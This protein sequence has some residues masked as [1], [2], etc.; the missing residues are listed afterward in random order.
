MLTIKNDAWKE[1]KGL[2]KPVSQLNILKRHW[3]G[4]QQIYIT[5]LASSERRDKECGVPS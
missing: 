4:Q 3:H 1:G 2:S 5:A